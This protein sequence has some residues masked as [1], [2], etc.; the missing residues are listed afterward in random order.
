MKGGRNMTEIACL[1]CGKFDGEI[2][3]LGVGEF[4][5]DIGR[6]NGLGF[7]AFRCPCSR[8]L[9][10]QILESDH[11]LLKVDNKKLPKNFTQELSLD[12]EF[13]TDEVIDFYRELKDIK[14]ID[15]FLSK[16]YNPKKET[17]RDFL[18]TPFYQ[19]S[20]LIKLFNLINESKNERALVVTLD[21]YRILKGWK[22][23]GP[24]TDYDLSLNPKEVF[25]Q[26]LNVEDECMIYIIDNLDIN[27]KSPEREEIMKVNR[28][29]QAGAILGIKFKDRLHVDGNQFYSFKKLNLI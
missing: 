5:K 7:V 2:E 29:R 9:Q 13:S 27:I 22:L 25:E 20:Q 11:P 14:D 18:K 24:G 10:Y 17:E 1:K 16:C 26:A 4:T 8:E 23:M 15:C 12:S 19:E 28:L 6:L 3:I 21:R